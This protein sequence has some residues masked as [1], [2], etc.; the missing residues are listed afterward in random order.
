MLSLLF[1]FMRLADRFC[2]Y[3]QLEKNDDVIFFVYVFLLEGILVSIFSLF[4]FVI[5]VLYRF[6]EI[7]EKK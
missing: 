4:W 6:T 2:F 3:C 1:F 5:R 7:N